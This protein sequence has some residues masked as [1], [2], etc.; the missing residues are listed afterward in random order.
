MQ[1]G[2]EFDGNAMAGGMD[3]H[4][5]NFDHAGLTEGDFHKRMV[6]SQEVEVSCVSYH[7]MRKFLQEPTAT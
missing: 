2:A 5:A 4:D 7:E 1:T 6:S 3:G